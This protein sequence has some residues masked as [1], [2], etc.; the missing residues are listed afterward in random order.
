MEHLSLCTCCITSLL[1]VSTGAWI[2]LNDLQDQM[3]FEW[4]D[5]SPVRVTYWQHSEPNNWLGKREDCVEAI[6]F[7]EVKTQ[8]LN[9]TFG[10]ILKSLLLANFLYKPQ[11]NYKIWD[12]VRGKAYP[13]D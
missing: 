6:S 9:N 2:G 11:L 10:E 1:P 13:L 5:G 3:S 12:D 4:A 8:L 7:R